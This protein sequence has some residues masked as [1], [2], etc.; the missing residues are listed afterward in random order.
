MPPTPASCA[1]GRP[2]VCMPERGQGAAHD[3]NVLQSVFRDL[4]TSTHH[5]M[6]DF[7]NTVEVQGR[8]LFGAELPASMV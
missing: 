3:A 5:A 7:D 1:D 2:I 6:L 4:N 8:N